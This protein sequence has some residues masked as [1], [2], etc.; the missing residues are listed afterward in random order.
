[1]RF[2]AYLSLFTF[3]MLMLVTAD[4][5]A[6]IFFGW[7]GVCLASY[8]LIGF[9]FKKPSATAAAMKAFLVNRVGELVLS[10]VKPGRADVFLLY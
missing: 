8:L 7:E 6:Q 1:P 10:S 9:W 4:N 5:L 2:F 3:A